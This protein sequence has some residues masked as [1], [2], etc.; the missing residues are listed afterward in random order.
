M[1]ITFIAVSIVAVISVLAFIVAVFRGMWRVP[2]PNEA[3]IITGRRSKQADGAPF[4][5]VAGYGVFV[6][7]GIEHVSRLSLGQRQAQLVSECKTN[8]F[9]DVVINGVAV[10]KIGDDTVSI[11]NA[12][13]RFLDKPES[14]I[15]GTV[16]NL[17]DAHTRSII[18]GLTMEEVTTNRDRLLSE[19]R[20]S[21]S[22]DMQ[23][24]GLV[25]DS[26]Q[27]QEIKDLTT[28]TKNLA[29]P[30]LAQV[31]MSARI[32]KAT[33]D[34]Q[35]TKTEQTARAQNADSIREAEIKTAQ[36]QADIDKAKAEAAQAG[37]LAQAVAKQNVTKAET[38][39][40]QLNAD[41][42]EQTL[43]ATVRKPADAEAYAIQ[44]N[45]AAQRDA[46]I[47]AAEAEA[48]RIE[49]DAT[50]KANA[51]K[52]TGDAEASAVK[53]TSLAQAEGTK[54]KLLAE[55]EGI[56]AR[57]D[58]LADN[59]EAVLSQMII[60]KFPDMIKAGASMYD[61]VKTLTVLDG[62]DG[63]T[64]G[65]GSVMGMANSLAPMFKGAVSAVRNAIAPT[66]DVP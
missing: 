29:L 63:M 51:T 23:K 66:I 38:V 15:I 18:G 43:Q 62:H 52:I 1:D 16:Q 19:I 21:T 59:Q 24:M 60:E 6:T 36:Y 35:A 44:V 46:S 33:N 28:Y 3:F 65:I 47:S 61:N 14:V 58:A 64:K 32:A 45:A 42:A 49:L 50:A 25:L 26:L 17:L 30:H 57:A 22:E 53:A 5:V 39:T 10:F 20:T 7:P 55:A 31:E 27:I 8:Q 56:K 34:Q 9:L 40:A 37:P 54:A 11:S 41:L 2:E 12:A 4:K 48:K 13:R